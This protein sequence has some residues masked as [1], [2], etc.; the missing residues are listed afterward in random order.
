M[1]RQNRTISPPWYKDGLDF[2][3]TRCGRCCGGA[4]GYV[5][6]SDEEI[7][8]AAGF[9]EIPSE[10]F[11]R[12]YTRRLGTRRSLNE[13]DNGDCEF[14][15]YDETG[16][17]RC[18]IHAVRPLQCRTWPFWKSNLRSRRAWEMAA[19]DCPGMNQG[20][21]HGLPVIQGALE[22][23]DHADLDL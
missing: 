23:N 4:P 9:M 10:E 12:R 2:S 5:W 11:T 8:T 7:R 21:H 15:A 22:R 14:L 17:A 20:E 6:V 3:C 19:R 18:T 13:L 1:P 16:L